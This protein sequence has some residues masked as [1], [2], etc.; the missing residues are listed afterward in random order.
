M[1][2]GLAGRSMNPVMGREVKE[3][4]RGMRGW[5]MLIAYLAVLAGVL[6]LTYQATAAA[7]NDPFAGV[8]ATRIATVGRIIF[9]TLVIFMLLLVL[10]LVPAMTSGAVAGERERQTLVP[11]QVTLLRPLSILLGKIGASL[12]FTSLLVVAALPFLAVTYLVGGVT[13]TNVVAAVVAVLFVSVA[14]ACLGVA[15]SAI[16][17]RVQAATVI[18][19]AVVLALAAG[20]FVAYGA[21]M[22][23]DQ[24]RG[25]DAVSRAPAELLAVNPFAFTADLVTTEAS[26]D[27]GPLGALDRFIMQSRARGDLSDDGFDDGD[28][29]VVDGTERVPVDDFGQPIGDCAGEPI[30]FDRFGNPIC[31]EEVDSLVPF[32]AESAV[33]LYALAAAAVFL[34]VRRLRTP[35]AAER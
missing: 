20:T 12:A 5:V 9:E 27:V 34:G 24:A 8:D 26:A 30:G 23:I 21:W 33:A 18:T 35:A 19:Y 15:C 10:F 32:W 29:V 16:F 1:N 2:V 14:V 28:V 13:I 31:A 11:L 7:S 17:R 4:F 3:R 22:L 25:T 6:F